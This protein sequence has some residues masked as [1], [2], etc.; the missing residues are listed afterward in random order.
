MSRQK[1]TQ[2]PP[3]EMASAECIAE[4]EKAILVTGPDIEKTWVPKG[5]VLE[6]S[7]VQGKG[8]E[9]WLVV[10]AWIA[11]EKSWL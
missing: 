1:Q 10:T 4:T 11:K 8:D 2:E 6:A 5:H 7:E 9:G 3:F